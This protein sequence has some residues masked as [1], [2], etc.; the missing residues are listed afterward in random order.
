MADVVVIGAGM[1]GVAAGRD[2]Q[3]AGL[4]V[5]V[6]ESTDRIGGRVMTD[7]DLCGHPVELGAEFVHTIEADTWPDIREAGFAVREVDP[8]SSYWLSMDGKS[9]EELIAEPGV[10]A[11]TGLLDEV[12]SW[13]G[14]DISVAEL[15][16]QRGYTG[17]AREMA[18]TM[19]TLHPAGDAN[20]LGLVGLHD[21][22][23]VDLELGV[24]HR[25]EA[26]YEKLP[27]WV[28][29]DLDV[30]YGFRVSDI[31]WGATYVTVRSTTGEEI[32]TSAGV[33]TL[34]VGVLKSGAVRFHPRLPESKLDALQGLEMGAVLKIVFHFEER[35]WPAEP[36]VLGCDGPVRTYWPPLH[37]LGDDAPAVLTA[38]VTG[39]RAKKL[40][41]CSADEAVDTGLDDLARLF[42][43]SDPHGKLQAARRLNWPVTENALGGYPFV[44]V[45]GAGSRAAL[46]APD[47][48]ALHWAGDA[49]ATDTI[50]SV[51]HAAYATGRRAAAEITRPGGT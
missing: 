22:R 51:V 26:G 50:A 46:A 23:I 21:D 3:A 28:G 16:E 35:F 40:S 38:Y 8:T 2:L 37:G 10:A 11:V 42:P 30:R 18:D 20:E 4:D 9:L 24:D 45:G 39:W 15:F 27:Q 12:A 7:Y 1:A 5:V 14:P 43:G 41:V 31:A 25:L 34:P 17:S 48:G 36:A 33:C 29:R 49:T 47:T 19:L 44:R 32:T 13:D 6:V